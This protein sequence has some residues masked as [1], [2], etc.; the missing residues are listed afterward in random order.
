MSI[1]I[2]K[3]RC[4][5]CGK[6]QEVCPGNLL[7]ADKEKKAFIKYPAECWGCTACIKECRAQAIKYFLGADI[8]GKGSLLSSSSQED[9]LDWI[10]ESPCGEVKKI[11]INKKAAN[12]Y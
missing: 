6:C 10:I 1:V 5:A 2:N 11:A 3:D 7:K 9:T 12:N 8:G 4:I